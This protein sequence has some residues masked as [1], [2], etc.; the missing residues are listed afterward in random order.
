[1]ILISQIIH[2]KPDSTHIPV[3]NDGCLEYTP[4]VL[5]QKALQTLD[6][7]ITA[8]KPRQEYHLTKMSFW[9]KTLDLLTV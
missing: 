4:V 1:M 9:D 6:I 8:R 7:A 3:E 5:P 2:S